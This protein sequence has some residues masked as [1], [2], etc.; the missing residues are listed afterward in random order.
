MDLVTSTGLEPPPSQNSDVLYAQILKF[1][2][3]SAFQSVEF[4]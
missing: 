3:E 4:T 1:E 2:F